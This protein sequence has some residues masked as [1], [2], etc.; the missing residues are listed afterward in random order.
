[1]YG[2]VPQILRFTG[3]HSLLNL[4][5]ADLAFLLRLLG[6]ISVVFLLFNFLIDRVPVLLPL[7]LETH[8]FNS[9]FRIRIWIGSGVNQVSKFVFGIRIRIQEGKNFPQKQ[10]KIKNFHVFKC[11]TF[12]FEGGRLLL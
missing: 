1:M 12:S 3:T 4:V 11:W 5:F 7:A 2:T 8:M 10:K 6:K 9:V